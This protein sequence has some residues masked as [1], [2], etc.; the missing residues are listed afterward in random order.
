MEGELAI[1]RLDSPLLFLNTGL[2]MG[3]ICPAHRNLVGAVVA[4]VKCT[5]QTKVEEG[6]PVK[7]AA[8]S[9]PMAR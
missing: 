4:R 3:D 8:I 5:P 2:A 7:K 6:A 1:S 9:F